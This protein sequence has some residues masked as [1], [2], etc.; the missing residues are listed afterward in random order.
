[1]K[2]ASQ[3]RSVGHWNANDAVDRVV[4]DTDERHRR[5]TVL[6]GMATMTPDRWTARP[7]GASL[8]KAKC[9]PT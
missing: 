5:R 6:I 2:R 4:L 9:V 8:P 3:I 1:M 7:R